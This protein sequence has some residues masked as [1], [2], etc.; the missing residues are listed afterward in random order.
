[1]LEKTKHS[2]LTWHLSGFMRIS[3]SPLFCAVRT[4]F[5]W[6]LLLGASPLLLI[7]ELSVVWLLAV[8]ELPFSCLLWFLFEFMSFFVL[9]LLLL[10][11]LLL[12]DIGLDTLSILSTISGE[13]MLSC[14]GSITLDALLFGEW[15][16]WCEI[17]EW[18]LG[19]WAAAALNCIGIA[20]CGGN[21]AVICELIEVANN[22][23]GCDKTLG[24]ITLFGKWWFL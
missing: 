12:T 4:A 24:T 13:P 10:L 6:K 3:I 21:D 19:M 5:R 18:L 20:V 17:V 8:A 11:L 2:Q 9:L 23:I 1:M 22:G 7:L 15:C 14:D 16:D